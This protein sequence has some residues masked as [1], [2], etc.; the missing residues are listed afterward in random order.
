MKNVT[1]ADLKMNIYLPMIL[2]ANFVLIAWMVG[3]NAIKKMFY[4]NTS[5]SSRPNNIQRSR[6]KRRRLVNDIR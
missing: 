4:Y 2:M 1:T 3:H 6:R 5:C